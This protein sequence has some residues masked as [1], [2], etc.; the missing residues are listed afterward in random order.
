MEMSTHKMVCPKTKQQE[1]R[2]ASETIGPEQVLGTWRL[3]AS[4]AVDAAG[5]E[6]PAPYG[7]RPMGRLVLD[8]AGRMM[9]VLCDGRPAMA[10]GETRAYGSYCGNFRV[11][12][13]TLITTVDAAAV[14][15]RIGGQ[16]IRK[17][18]FRDGLLVLIPPR[19]PDGEQREL[20]WER[21]G[22]P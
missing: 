10:D 18:E 9:A 11:E 8:A 21:D 7:P 15:E 13:N 3:V 20:F 22:P 19:R 12:K 2:M 16:Q 5:R 1:D 17:L 4:T 14:S 6:L